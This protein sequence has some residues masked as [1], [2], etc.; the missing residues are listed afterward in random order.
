MP[1]GALF[2]QC[3]GQTIRAQ[4]GRGIVAQPLGPFNHGTAVI[5]RLVQDLSFDLSIEVVPT[6]RE[7][8]GLAMSS[9]NV[10]LDAHS[11]KV[12]VQLSKVLRSS[13]LK[14]E[15]YKWKVV[16]AAKSF[17]LK[18]FGIGATNKV[19]TTS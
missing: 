7:K 2:G 13:M 19:K 8:D 1:S 6:R 18:E 5:K 12:A 15:S 3:H 14:V 17:L 16:I 11:R 10:R 4:P 9:R